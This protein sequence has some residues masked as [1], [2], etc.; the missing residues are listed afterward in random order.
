M[1]RLYGQKNYLSNLYYVF[2]ELCQCDCL[3]YDQIISDG[4]LYQCRYTPHE[5][6]CIM[7]SSSVIFRCEQVIR[8]SIKVILHSEFSIKFRY[9]HSEAWWLVL[10]SHTEEFC[11][12]LTVF[13]CSFLI[14]LFSFLD[15][16]QLMKKPLIMDLVFD[17]QAQ[18][19]FHLIM[20]ILIR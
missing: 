2:V 5:G 14:T 4:S 15:V 19:K 1:G 8:R 11:Y 13:L 6:H 16:F 3:T 12:Q 20:N 10:V 9:I 7:L 17:S 18:L